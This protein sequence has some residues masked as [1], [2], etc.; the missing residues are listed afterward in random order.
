MLEETTVQ[1]KNRQELVRI[2]PKIQK[3]VKNFKF[4][5]GFIYLFL[6]HTTATFWLN[7]DEKGLK[8]DV[9][10]F[11]N[12]LIPKEN[13]QHNKIDNNAQAH[14]LSGLIKPYLFLV[15]EDG[16]IELGV[17]QEIFLLE[18]DGPRKRKVKIKFIPL[19]NNKMPLF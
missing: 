5:C 7:E 17:W 19:P 2:T 3:V 11:L 1:T 6:P 14:L 15:V 12:R 18:L 16:K 9:L 10:D 8:K 13:W 4:S